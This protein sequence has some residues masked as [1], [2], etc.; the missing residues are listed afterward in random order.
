M[1][2]GKPTLLICLALGAL[3]GCAPDLPPQVVSSGSL[4]RSG[5]AEFVLI[6]L[7]NA[8]VDDGIKDMQACLQAAG[9]SAGPSPAYAVQLSRT[10]R[11]RATRTV[12]PDD[13]SPAPKTRG[14]RQIQSDTVSIAALAGGDEVY[15]LRV[16]GRYKPMPGRP[17]AVDGLFCQTLKSGQ[18][19][20]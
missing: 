17:N 18:A 15:R 10:L 6:G 16:T 2:T 8:P 19:A 1:L 9:L 13:K 5:Q 12:L 14:H 7:G 4:P 11:D 3:S 20:R